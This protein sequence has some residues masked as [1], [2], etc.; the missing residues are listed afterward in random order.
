MYT[1]TP[2]FISSQFILYALI[3]AVAGAKQGSRNKGQILNTANETRVR[4]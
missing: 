4:S 2:K 3:A 1:T